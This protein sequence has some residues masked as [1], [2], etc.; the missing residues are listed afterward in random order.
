[1]NKRKITRFD[2]DSITILEAKNLYVQMKT[3]KGVTNDCI[4]NFITAYELFI[5]E[6]NLSENDSISVITEQ[7]V[8]DWIDYMMNTKHLKPESVNAYLSRLR[9]FIYYCMDKHDLNSFKV[10]LVAHQEEDLKYYTDDELKIMLKK[11]DNKCSFTDY[12]TWVIIC[13]ILG[14]GAR[15]ATISNIKL[16][17]VDF[18]TREV[19][20][21]HL[22]NKKF[23]VI[24][25]STGLI[26]ILSE[27]LRTWNLHDCE[28]LFCDVCEGQLT[29]SAI[30]QALNKYCKKRNVQALG[31]HALRNSFA[32]GWIKNGGGVFQLQQ[33]LTHSD[34]AMTRRYVKLFSDDLQD[35]V[36]QFNPLDTLRQGTTRTKAVTRK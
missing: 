23:A 7:V 4:N 32:R 8:F 26:N 2:S 29:T 33:M 5:R 14:T 1:M 28:Y 30:R 20:Y 36:K 12:R 17:D 3:S 6:N 35:D 22:K 13:F 19:R 18:K 15:A 9:T 16:E 24:P 31:P 21:R 25:L 11:P 27:Y 10:K 34:L